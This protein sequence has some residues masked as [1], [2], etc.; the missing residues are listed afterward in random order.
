MPEKLLNYIRFTL[1][2]LFSITAMILFQMWNTEHAAIAP[3]PQQPAISLAATNNTPYT[4]PHINQVQAAT[5]TTNPSAATLTTTTPATPA[6]VYV[7]TNVLTVAI[8]LHGGNIVGSTLSHYPVSLSDHTPYQL[9]NDAPATRYVAESGLLGSDGP[10]TV[11]TQAL[12]SSPQQQYLMSAHDQALTVKLHWHNKNLSITKLFYFQRDNYQITVSYQIDNHAQQP[13]KGNAYT[14]LVRTDTSPH[15]AGIANFT[16][17]FGA[18]LSTPEKTFQ[19]ITFPEIQ[20]NN[21]NRTG[22]GGWI[23]M[24]QHYFVSAWIPPQATINNYYTHYANNGLYVIGTFSQD[25]SIPPHSSQHMTIGKLYSGPALADQL[26]KAAKGLQ[27]T[28]DY[29]W[30]WFLSIIIF[31]MM[32]K[33][34]NVIGNWGWSIVLVTIII[35]LLFYQLSAKSYRSMSAMKKLQP[36]I[37]QLR[38]QYKE[39]KQKFTQATLELYRKEKVNPMSGCLPILIQIPV[40]IALYWVLI[41]S[42]ELRQAPFILWIRDL[43]QYDPYYCLPILVGI[44]M[45]LQQR[46]SPP[47]PDPVQAKITLCMPII[48]VALFLHFPAGLMLYWFVNNTLSCLQQWLV[49]RQL[50]S[51]NRYA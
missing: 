8:D 44:S 20:S 38:E 51:S 36:C 15:H 19:K 16:T 31:G 2:A 21:L 26:E 12:F 48:F 17:Y 40:F 50:S 7:K 1:Y 5:Q 43:S 34:F 39:D 49:M 11:K 10:D 22:Q 23:A 41:E 4:I 3:S 35:K 47:P 29:G 14:Q 27:L 32:E 24:I 37:E 42:V 9:L 18:A 45:F 13:W 30:F 33:I 46:L 25:I 28:I 6:L